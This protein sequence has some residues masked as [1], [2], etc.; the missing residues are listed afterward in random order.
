MDPGM[1]TSLFS[2][3]A[4]PHRFVGRATCPCFPARDSSC[5]RSGVL[6]TYNHMVVGLRN[7]QHAD[8]VFHALADNTR[9]EIVERA[10][11]GEHS[12]SDL[13][14]HFPMSF[15]AVQKH[16]AVLEGAG[17]I[18]KHKRGREKLVRTNMETVRAAQN[19]L[20]QLE[21]T[22][23]GRVDRMEQIINESEED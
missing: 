11:V 17:L 1:C 15:A 20:D 8:R 18:T 2:R 9:R 23:R 14:R 13:S 19:L 4:D 10:M 12:V 5:P 16:V 3:I 6:I 21:A 22:W 7:E